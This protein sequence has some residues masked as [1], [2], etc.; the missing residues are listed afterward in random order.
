M[1]TLVDGTTVQNP[2]FGM[3]LSRNQLYSFQTDDVRPVKARRQWCLSVVCVY[4]FLLS[5]LNAFLVY[6]VFTMETSLTAS[7]PAR[8]VSDLQSVINN[9]SHLWSLQS[10]MKSMYGENGQLEQLRKNVNLLNSSNQNLERKMSSMNLAAGPPGRT[11]L[12]GQPGAPGEKGPKGDSGTAGPPGLRGQPGLRGEP[13]AAGGL[14]LR[15]PPG[16]SGPTGAK[17]ERG[18]SG[19]PGPQGPKG[20][21][22][23]RGQKGDTGTAGAPGLRGQPG[24]AGGPGELHHDPVPN[25]FLKKDLKEH[26]VHQ[27]IKD[28]KVQR[29]GEEPL[30][31]QALKDKKE[32]LG[33]LVRKVPHVST[34]VLLSDS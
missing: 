11:G 13:G 30:G 24:A 2:L 16:N 1:E 20:D 5:A 7:T 12:P 19:I 28:L 23:I 26:E 22:G 6:K 25:E 21:I 32:T 31:S 3:S 29:G 15:G 14:G 34:W 9:S 27:E 10:Q 8:L 18:S 33:F 4:I 17:G